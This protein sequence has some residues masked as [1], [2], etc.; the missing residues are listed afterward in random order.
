[1]ENPEIQ[2]ETQKLRQAAKILY[3]HVYDDTE[4]TQEDA[5][6]MRQELQYLQKTISLLQWAIE[7]VS[8]I[9]AGYGSE[10]IYYDLKAGYWLKIQLLADGPVEVVPRPD[11]NTIYVLAGV[12][13]V[14][15]IIQNVKTALEK[16]LAKYM[17][18]QQILQQ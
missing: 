4:F 2:A 11:I 12:G 6:E 5:E 14:L 3:P 13:P 7:N 17:Q 8:N 9:I 16:T 18:V 1:M 15:Q 10:L